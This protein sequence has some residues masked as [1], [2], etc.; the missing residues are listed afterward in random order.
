V[1]ALARFILGGVA[2]G[3][4]LVLIAADILSTW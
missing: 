1:M 4:G 2:I 3:F